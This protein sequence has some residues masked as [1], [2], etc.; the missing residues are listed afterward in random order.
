MNYSIVTFLVFTVSMSLF[1]Q[2]QNSH[3]EKIVRL[4]EEVRE[5]VLESPGGHPNPDGNFQLTT[6]E[7]D[8]L[9]AMAQQDRELLELS[10][11]IESGTNIPCNNLNLDQTASIEEK[12]ENNRKFR[13]LM[14]TRYFANSQLDKAKGFFGMEKYC[15][16]GFYSYAANFSSISSLLGADFS[17]RKICF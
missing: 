3:I 2:D 7:T 17:S 5:I 15:S 12:S 4:S 14:T 10:N 11:A 6:E 9:W 16:L 13:I 8:L 1:A